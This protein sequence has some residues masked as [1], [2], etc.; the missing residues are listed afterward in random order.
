MGIKKCN[1]LLIS[2]FLSYNL[3]MQK[4]NTVFF[5]FFNFSY[6]SIPVIGAQ[7]LK[8]NVLVFSEVNVFVQK[9]L[10]Q[11]VRAKLCKKYQLYY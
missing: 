3:C 8:A 9:S 10:D 6:N 5:F 7:L 2:N 11:C 1:Y 4:H